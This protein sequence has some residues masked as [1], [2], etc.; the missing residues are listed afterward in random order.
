MKDVEGIF[1]DGLAVFRVLVS[2]GDQFLQTF[3]VGTITP[4]IELF[5]TR[6][7]VRIRSESVFKHQAFR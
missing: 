3:E 4:V 1:G 6:Q 2:F 7:N 5:P